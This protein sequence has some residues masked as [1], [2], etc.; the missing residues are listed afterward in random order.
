MVLTLIFHN[1][2]QR[3]FNVI[4]FDQKTHTAA[5]LSLNSP[6]CR[7]DPVF[8]IVFQEKIPKTQTL[9]VIDKEDVPPKVRIKH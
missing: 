9:F 2:G 6:G 8:D 4:I 5:E 3:R 7:S 1:A